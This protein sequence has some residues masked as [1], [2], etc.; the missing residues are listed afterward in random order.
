MQMRNNLFS[1]AHEVVHDLG[2]GFNVV[3]QTTGLSGIEHGVVG[4]AC[5]AR[6]G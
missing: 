5:K 2:C 4:L 3:Y 1:L 6:V